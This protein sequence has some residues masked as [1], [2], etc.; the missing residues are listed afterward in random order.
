[1]CV[2]FAVVCVCVVCVACGVSLCVLWYVL[3]PVCFVRNA[4]CVV[5]GGVDRRCGMR[6]L[7][8]MCVRAVCACVVCDV[9]DQYCK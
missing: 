7:C 6:V 9:P 2:V 1:M 8:G 4:L 5:G 3:C